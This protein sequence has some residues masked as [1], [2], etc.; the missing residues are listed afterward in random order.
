MTYLLKPADNDKKPG[1]HVLIIGAGKY[2]HLKGGKAKLFNNHDGMGQLSPPPK[3]VALLSQWFLSNHNFPSCPC[4]SVDVLASGGSGQVK[5]GQGK[6]VD[7]EAATTENVRNAILRWKA[8][9]DRNAD[10]TL[11][12]YFCGHGVHSGEIHS[13]LLEDFGSDVDDPFMH[14]LA[15][16]KF[17][18]GMK[19]CGASKQLYMLDACQTVSKTYLDN[20]DNT[21]IAVID[22][23]KSQTLGNLVQPVIR[24]SIPGTKAFG[25]TDEPSLFANGFV[26]VLKGAACSLGDNG[27]W[28]VKTG[29]LLGALQELVPKREPEV[30]QIASGNVAMPFPFHELPNPSRPEIPV[31]V[32]CVPDEKMAKAHLA[33]L[34][35]NEA[36]PTPRGKLDKEPW[37]LFLAMGRY[38]FIADFP[39]SG[40]PAIKVN[41]DVIPAVATV[42]I[43]CP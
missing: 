37:V 40:K 27:E 7:I 22:A 41:R 28:L 5:N 10:N 3:S 35:E 32:T 30:T 42:K 15:S 31:W 29:N 20:Y 21:G 14:A 25:R 26:D 36:A 17:I 8:L 12:F 6:N 33:Y 13:L 16:N 19:R 24:A 1:T 23:A 39:Q 4:R 43:P 18:S 2:P 38:D 9:G 11:I 34:R